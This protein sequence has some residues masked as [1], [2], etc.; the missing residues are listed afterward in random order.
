[1]MLDLR[2]STRLFA[3]IALCC[4]FGAAAVAAP[5]DRS[6]AK[7][8]LEPAYAAIRSLQFTR[9][10]EL[11]SDSTNAGNPDAQ[12]LL[13]LMYL[14]GVGV[15]PDPR[16]AR[17]LL[18]AAADHDHAAAAYVLASELERDPASSPVAAR[19][20]LERSAKLGYAR[21]IE[22][23]RSG[24]V[25]L[26]P[27]IADAAEP[28]L[29]AA[30]VMDCARKNDWRQLERL[31]PRSAQVLDDFGRGALAHAAETGSVE[32]AQVLL[33]FKAD[34]GAADK[35]GA[36]PL[37]LAAA[38]SSAVMTELLLQHGADLETADA[39]HRNAL[40]Y[41]ARADRLNNLRAL[42]HAGA[43]L[44][45][46]DGRS[47]NALEA[48][49]ADGAQETVSE[50]RSL[51]L[52]ASMSGTDSVRPS[53]KFDPGHPGNLYR[54]WPAIALAVSRNDTDGVARFLGAGVS[55]GLYLPKGDTLLQAAADARAL[56][57]LPLLRAH[58]ADPA[59]P[60]HSGHTVLWLAVERNDLALVKALLAA[61]VTPDTRATSED[62]PLVAAL[63]GA[64]PEIAQA[65]WAAGADSQAT[66]GQG[67]T[68]LMVASSTGQRGSIEALLARH[69]PV[70]AKDA[71]GR[72]ALWY[73]AAAGATE[74]V[75][76]LLSAGAILSTDASGI[77]VLH[78]AAAQPN[79]G[80]LEV[81]LAAH[82]DVNAR[83]GNGDSLLMVAAAAG[84]L[85]IVR[86]LL[87]RSP[88]LDAQNQAGDTALI[89]ASR[90]GHAPVC[91]LLLAAGAN[92]A[93]RN[94]ARVSA[95][96]IAAGRGFAPIAAE[97][98]GKG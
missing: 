46:R 78:A 5:A 24:R 43:K 76:V 63:R 44:D 59:A 22:A 15:V 6:R 47:Y 83:A 18:R 69:A 33:D 84:H 82:A 35:E 80:T 55:G 64:H 95:A 31:G 92:R 52:K 58:G 34:V 93:L 91:H 14:N 23:S 29:F 50:L 42:V 4:T 51:G 67:R 27:E 20:W 12:Y 90:A 37:M 62:P 32:A 41:A 75:S 54:D 38:Q 36:R 68:P 77:G 57:S 60:D 74:A 28:L 86:A 79:T 49:L 98:A 10:V 66:D 97:I 30:R 72:S 73:A 81:L 61:G 70:D 13:G 89:I 8:A 39:E 94:H 88:D 7:R 48:A 9:A 65:L 40:N 21:A 96:D 1:M 2:P 3:S 19:E 87:A 16:R 17:G 45:S 53:G 11:L 25:L 71:K 56:A 85:E 26:A